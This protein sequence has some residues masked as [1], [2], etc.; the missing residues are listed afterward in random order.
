MR[1]KNNTPSNQSVYA[2]SGTGHITV[3]G[4]ASLEL[5]DDVWKKEYAASCA[6]QIKAGVLEIT[7]APTLT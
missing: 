7:K 1:I 6:P 2:A 4:D 3:V 5:D